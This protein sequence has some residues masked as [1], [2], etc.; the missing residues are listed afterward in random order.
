MAQAIFDL[1]PS[2]HQ[3]VNGFTFAK[4]QDHLDYLVKKVDE[5]KQRDEVLA[6]STIGNVLFAALFDPVNLIALPVGIGKNAISAGYNV[7]KANA[8]L[9]LAEEVVVSSS[10]PNRR[11]LKSSAVNIGLAGAAGFTLGGIVGFAT[12]KGSGSTIRKVTEAAR[13]EAI[14]FDKTKPVSETNLQ[15]VNEEFDPSQKLSDFGPV[16]TDAGI[17]PLP[18]VAADPSIVKNPFTNSWFNKV[19]TS[20]YK[21][22]QMDDQVPI[23]T[24]QTQYLLDGDMGQLAAGNQNGQT[25]GISV[26]AEQ[27]QYQAEMHKFYMGMQK[28]YVKS[29]KTV[30]RF[31]DY[32]GGPF[33]QKDFNKFMDHIGRIHVRGGKG[34]NQAEEEAL[35]L[36]R[37]F[38]K[39]WE[40]RLTDTGLIG[41]VGHYEKSLEFWNRV[42]RNNEDMLRRMTSGEMKRPAWYKKVVGNR[43]NNY[44]TVRDDVKD[45]IE[46]LRGEEVMPSGD[47]NFF[48]RYFKINKIKKEKARFTQILTDYYYENPLATVYDPTNPKLK[49][50]V[51]TSRAGAKRRAEATV[52]RMI[53]DPDDADYEKAFFGQGKSKHFMHRTLDIPNALVEDF[54]ETNPFT[55]FMAYNQKV[56]PRYSFAKKF[57]GK[58]IAQIK[59]EQMDIMAEAGLD[60]D[61]INRVLSDLQTSYDRVMNAP[62]RNP[63][64]WDATV[65]KYLKDIATFNYMGAVGLSSIPEVGRIIAEHGLSKSFAAM[66]ARHTDEKVKL[67][68]EEGRKAGEALEGA[69]FS[70][71]MRFSDEQAHNP[72]VHNLWEQGKEA[73]YILNGLTPIT[74]GLKN[75]DALFA[76]ILLLTWR[77]KRRQVTLKIGNLITYAA[78]T[79]AK[80]NQSSLQKT[81]GLHGSVLIAALSMP[82]QMSGLMKR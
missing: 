73:F 17:E 5:S 15:I 55:V 72:M 69:L 42:I 13:E 6:N 27:A 60:E 47:K 11:D 61:K 12:S 8:A 49:V 50:E 56:A 63:Q 58:T 23:E 9:Q 54:I 19:L 70:T 66:I 76:K 40:E 78:I 21:R 71:S 43:I 67:A 74:R 20:P 81:M 4:N 33:R 59:D 36:M 44:K 35:N 80:S 32:A 18:T 65:V 28:A 45:T 77:S 68:V 75:L 79:L 10:D 26:H 24:K 22:T 41:S 30:T 53:R 2:Y 39:R 57:K 37:D 3:Y 62:L 64:R 31:L 7:A 14:A 25:L 16:G 82:T 38:T 51:D 52:D 46:R 1:D 34:A 29:G 48:P